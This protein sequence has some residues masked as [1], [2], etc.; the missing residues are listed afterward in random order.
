MMEILRKVYR[1]DRDSFVAGCYRELLGREPDPDGMQHHLR[2]LAGGASKLTVMTSLLQCPEADRLYRS[3]GAPGSRR[4]P[5]AADLFRRLYAQSDEAYV[6]GLY[7]EL[8]CRRPDRHGCKQNVQQL[9]RGAS[10]ATVAAQLLQS[11][12][13]LELLRAKTGTPIAQ[14]ILFDYANRK[15]YPDYD[16]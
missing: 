6:Q 3:G 5:S 15:F 10:R 9:K 11:G 13:A 2:L 12:E 7:E 14:K 8:L 16:Y 4:R 1:K